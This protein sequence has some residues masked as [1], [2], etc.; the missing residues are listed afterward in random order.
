MVAE[1]E[2]RF[3]RIPVKSWLSFKTH[4]VRQLAAEWIRSGRG[5]EVV[6]EAELVAVRALGCPAPQLL[7]NGV[8]K[9]TW[10][11]RHV[12]PGARIHVDSP[13][14]ADVLLPLAGA[15]GW[16][17]GLRCH[18]PTE[19]DARERSFGGQFGMTADEFGA[20]HLILN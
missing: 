10:M 13:R 15:Q 6:S 1:Q 7:I 4:P 17:I 5:V 8:G 3:G 2:Q 11:H 12:I 14:E 16:R 18:V 20:T 9:H 19:Y